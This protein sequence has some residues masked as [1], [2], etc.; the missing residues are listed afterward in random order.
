[1]KTLISILKLEVDISKLNERVEESNKI[2]SKT[3]KNRQDKPD[4]TNFKP[5]DDDLRYI[6]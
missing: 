3:K 5:N 6:R 2:I 4:E 1:M